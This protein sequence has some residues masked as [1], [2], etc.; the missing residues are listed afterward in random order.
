MDT[1]GVQLLGGVQI[2][3]EE[4]QAVGLRH[5]EESQY[6]TIYDDIA[7]YAAGGVSRGA[8]KHVEWLLFGD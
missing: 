5:R 4:T 3:C 7:R 6:T 2:F 8:L 1:W